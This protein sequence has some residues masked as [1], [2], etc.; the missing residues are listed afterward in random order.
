MVNYALHLCVCMCRCGCG[1]VS[2]SPVVS[3]EALYNLWL[4]QTGWEAEEG[5]WA[6]AQAASFSLISISFS[7]GNT[8][9]ELYSWLPW[10]EIVPSFLSA[11]CGHATNFWRE[12]MCVVES[13]TLFFLPRPRAGIEK[14]RCSTWDQ[15]AEYNIWSKEMVKPQITKTI[16]SWWQAARQLCIAQAWTVR[17][18]MT[19][20]LLK[21]G[22]SLHQ[23]YLRAS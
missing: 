7:L 10:T 22:G 1:C 4:P 23:P 14:W 21:S 16:V 8:D 9:L 3:W 19:F 6:A 20:Y 5:S 18:E 12:E 17:W 2:N 15:M 13:S 11:R